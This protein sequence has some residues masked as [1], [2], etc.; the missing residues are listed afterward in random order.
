[1]KAAVAFALSAVCHGLGQ[2]YGWQAKKGVWMAAV[3]PLL[4]MLAGLTGLFLWF[5]AAALFVVILYTGRIFV[6]VEASR[7]IREGKGDQIPTEPRSAA[8]YVAGGLIVLLALVPTPKMFL[9][10]F[11]YF[12]AYHLPTDSMCPAV[13]LDERFV[14]QMDAFRTN[15]P[16]RGDIILFRYDKEA[17]LFVKR[18]IGVPGDVVS[19][20]G[21]TIQV[22]GQAVPD[23]ATSVVCG[24]PVLLPISGEKQ[25]P[26]EPVKVPKGAF[27]VIGDNLPHSFDSRYPGFGFVWTDQLRGKARYIY[28][29]P[30][31]SR[32]GCSIR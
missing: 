10:T 22:N 25:Q 6:A 13:C 4:V 9:D 23:T 16:Q 20:L 7:G 14:G 15:P 18:V 31:K 17:N 8:T 2:F 12:R 1:V 11:T 21:Q 26:F 24:K 29:S 5:W 32:I 19:S 27:F 30:G 28:W 3:F